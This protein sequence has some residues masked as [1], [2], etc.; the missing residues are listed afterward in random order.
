MNSCRIR[1]GEALG[2][3]VSLVEF[4][5]LIHEIV[6]PRCLVPSMQASVILEST[7]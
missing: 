4:G 5:G 1:R 7:I 3:R 2:K 6:P